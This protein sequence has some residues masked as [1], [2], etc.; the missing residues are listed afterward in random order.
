[1]AGPEGFEPTISGLEGLH[2]G[3]DHGSRL[4]ALS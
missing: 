4:G 2:A 1:M 3:V